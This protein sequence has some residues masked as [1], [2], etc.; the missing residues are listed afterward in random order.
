MARET[1]AGLTELKA[2]LPRQRLF[3]TQGGHDYEQDTHG[4]VLKNGLAVSCASLG[5]FGLPR[6]LIEGEVRR[7]ESV[8]FLFMR[9]LP[10]GSEIT[11]LV[12]EPVR[13]LSARPVTV[14]GELVRPGW[15]QLARAGLIKPL[16]P[17]PAA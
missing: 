2:T 12:T 17:W 9:Q 5:A 4:R 11:I 14:I 3:V 15:L 7:Y 8:A 13:L 10:H 16:A 1:R 6:L